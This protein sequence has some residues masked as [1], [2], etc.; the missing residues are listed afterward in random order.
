MDASDPF[1]AEYSM[2]TFYKLLQFR[3]LKMS[4]AHNNKDSYFL[5]GNYF[6]ANLPTF[7]NSNNEA[8]SN[9]GLSSLFSNLNYIPTNNG[10]TAHADIDSAIFYYNKARF[11][12]FAVLYILFSL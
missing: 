3:Q 6:S 8:I 7:S 4:S 10:D 9:G 1:P 12:T 5:L 2:E 11:V